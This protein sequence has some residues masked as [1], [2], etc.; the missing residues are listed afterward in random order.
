M[1][2]WI[3]AASGALFGLGLLVSGMTDT[4]KVQGFL[5]L[6]GD[7]DPTL[8]FVL[9]GAILPMVLAWRLAARRPASVVGEPFPER[10]AAKIDAPLLG[11]SALFGAGWALAGFCPG[12]AVAALGWSGASGLTFVLAMLAGML[13]LD[14]ARR[15][16]PAL[17]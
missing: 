7:W 6:A 12:P 13:G 11:G 8:A 17:A 14:W 3:S 4:A 10:P 5:D 15:R 2:P 16:L 1:R 9:G